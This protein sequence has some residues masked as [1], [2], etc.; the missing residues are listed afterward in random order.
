MWC[1]DVQNVLAVKTEQKGKGEGRRIFF[2]KLH[3]INEN[4]PKK[5][6]S[7]NYLLRDSYMDAPDSGTV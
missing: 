4:I 5:I 2:K 1:T 3:R 7:Q 6:G